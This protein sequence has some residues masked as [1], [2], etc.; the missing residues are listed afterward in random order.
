MIAFFTVT[1]SPV[2]IW[3]LLL[4]N[5]KQKDMAF[6]LTKKNKK[7]KDFKRKAKIMFR[8]LTQ[9]VF[10]YHQTFLLNHFHKHDTENSTVHIL[11][12]LC[13]CF[14]FLSFSFL[15]V[16]ASVFPL[17]LFIPFYQITFAHQKLQGQD[18]PLLSTK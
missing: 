5:I 14:I 8:F 7:F 4:L 16:H 3:K 2:L 6:V 10:M 15:S 1:C 13:F 11:F 9:F 17:C 12:S 18:S